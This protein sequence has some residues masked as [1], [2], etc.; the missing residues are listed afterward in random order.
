MQSSLPQD[1]VPIGAST[2]LA[3]ISTSC[4]IF[5]AIGQTVFQRRL[6]INLGSVV[7]PNTVRNIISGG[8]TNIASFVSSEELAPVIREYGKS[9]T[10][11]FV[12]YNLSYY[13]RSFN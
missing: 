5:N 2:L 9:I 3:I 6:E 11:V 8:A 12:S 1:L 13:S 4:A 7:S 10:Q